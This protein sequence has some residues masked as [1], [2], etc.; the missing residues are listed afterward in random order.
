MLN[1]YFI[2]AACCLGMVLVGFALQSGVDKQTDNIDS[3][4]M[5]VGTNTE[6]PPFAFLQNNT[7]VGFDI[8]IARE[9][10]KRMG[11]EILFKNMPFDALIPE[12]TLGHVHFVAAG[13]SKTE[14]R[15]KRVLFT[16][17][18]VSDDPLVILT[19]NSK[20]AKATV[21]D[22][23]IGKTIVVNDGYTSDL[24]LSSKEGFVLV[25]LA[26]PVD[27][28]MALKNGRAD[29]FVTAKSNLNS[30]LEAQPA[31][32]FHWTEIENTSQTCALIISKK[33]ANLLP[34]MQQTLD[35][36]SADGTLEYLKSKWKL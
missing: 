28:F 27:G 6:F 19:N 5:I 8:D 18:Y 26:T 1:K 15:A 16:Q 23:L 7:I 10:C 24:L 13:M 34:E 32:Q 29:A 22:D 21:L 12:V 25:R 20:D 31:D 2:I 35:G 11:K 9:V 4:V 14:E 17:S 30:F 36:M 33:H 3:K